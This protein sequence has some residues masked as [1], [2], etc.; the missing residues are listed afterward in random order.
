MALRTHPKKIGEGGYGCVFKPALECDNKIIK[1]K[2]TVG[3]LFFSDE[4]EDEERDIAILLS[5]FVPKRSISKYLIVPKDRCYTREKDAPH[6]IKNCDLYTELVRNNRKQFVQHIIPYGGQTLHKIVDNYTITFLEWI[7]ILL[8]LFQA[9][10]FMNNNGYAHLD[11]KPNNIVI[12]DRVRLIDF[13]F[14]RKLS[15]IYTVEDSIKATYRIYPIE[16]PLYWFQQKYADYNS[17]YNERVSN[18]V[19]KYARENVI[20][21]LASDSDILKSIKQSVKTVSFP[22]RA[23]NKIDVHCI[24]L[25]CINDLHPVLKH[26][27]EYAEYN[28]FIKGISHIDYRKRYSPSTAISELKKIIAIYESKMPPLNSTRRNNPTLKRSS[29]RLSQ[30]RTYRE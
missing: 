7:N 4:D 5:G 12:S 30:N 10:Q 23:A 19:N 24:G 2:N 20:G 28:K 21:K 22:K 26:F 6:I 1:R 18:A 11:I 9:V 3:K 27:D 8:Q 13:G 25:M 17:I 16:T 15:D 29:S 14:M